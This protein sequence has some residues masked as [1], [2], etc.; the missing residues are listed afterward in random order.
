MNNIYQVQTRT[1]RKENGVP[2]PH[3]WE[4]RALAV[5]Q[6]KL[7]ILRTE[8]S[9]DASIRTFLPSKF[10]SSLVPRQSSNHLWLFYFSFWLFG[11]SVLRVEL[12][13]TVCD[14]EENDQTH[15]YWLDLLAELRAWIRTRSWPRCRPTSTPS[16][17]RTQVR[18]GGP[19]SR[20]FWPWPPHSTCPSLST[21]WLRVGFWW[22]PRPCSPP[23]SSF[24]PGT[25][26]RHYS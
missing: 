15:N 6:P 5:F 17:L 26:E 7:V 23:G 12:E 8:P 24:F 13:L 18:S 9:I 22:P 11:A 21:P 4:S 14:R 16:S 1:E 3:L 20:I 10:V 19:T 25:L 2:V